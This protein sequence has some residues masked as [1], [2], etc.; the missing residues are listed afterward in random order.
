MV[1]MHKPANIILF[2]NIGFSINIYSH[3]V[4]LGQ[5][6]FTVAPAS[7]TVTEDERSFI[8]RLSSDDLMMSNDDIITINII[9]SDAGALNGTG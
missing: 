2:I 5:I 3:W 4:S 8:V 1:S 7:L 9:T 6:E